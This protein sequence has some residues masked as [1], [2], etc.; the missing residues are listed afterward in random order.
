[1]LVLYAILITISLQ[2]NRV[3]NQGSLMG[4]PA[5]LIE[6]LGYLK[7]HLASCLG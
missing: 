1:M 2:K 4:R 3:I 6:K 5:A 7:E